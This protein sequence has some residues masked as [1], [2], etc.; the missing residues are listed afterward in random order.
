[1]ASERRR[2]APVWPETPRFRSRIEGGDLQSFAP[3]ERYQVSLGSP[4]MLLLG[5]SSQVGSDEHGNPSGP[6]D[7]I[8]YI[9][10]L[11]VC[12]TT[13]RTSI[14]GSWEAVSSRV[15]PKRY[16]RLSDDAS[17]R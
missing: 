1:M 10:M 5:G 17:R 15:P 16:R 8:R 4:G 2:Q 11:K 12:Q 6:I 14:C 9:S 3:G 7:L 13:Y